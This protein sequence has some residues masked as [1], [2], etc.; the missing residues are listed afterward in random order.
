M[1]RVAITLLTFI[2]YG[3][4]MPVAVMRGDDGP[5]LSGA[6]ECKDMVVMWRVWKSG[7]QLAVTGGIRAVGP[8]PIRN[9]E[10]RVRH[11]TSA[12][13]ELGRATF[14]FF[15]TTILPG[16]FLHQ[17]L[18]LPVPQGKKPSRIEFVYAYYHE[19]DEAGVLPTFEGFEVPL[20]E[21]K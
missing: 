12:G 1:K 19:N 13:E 17:G 15:P 2:L 8:L 21:L 16:I 3:I 7:D 4:C 14:A 20:T 10:L 18:S 11:L 9:L 6:R 5:G